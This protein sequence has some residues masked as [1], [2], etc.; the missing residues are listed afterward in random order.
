MDY[1]VNVENTPYYQWQLELLIESF[2]KN[3]IEDKLFI[4]IST[5]ERVKINKDFY[6]NISSHKRIIFVKNVGEEKGF[7]SLNLPYSLHVAIE[8][9][10]ISQ[11]FTV[12]EPDMVLNHEIKMEATDTADFLFDVDP[13]FTLENAEKNVGNFCEWFGKDREKIKKDWFPIGICYALNNFPKHFF[14]KVTK[15]AE[16]LALHQL[17]QGNKIWSNTVKLSLA[18]NLADNLSKINA[19]GT[20]DLVSQATSPSQFPFISY[21]QGM[22]P[23]FHKSMFSYPPP[24]YFSFGDPIETLSNIYYT[25]NIKFVSELASKSLENRKK[26]NG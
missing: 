17:L 21:K 9:D 22:L 23:Q 16:K 26:N 8:K 18:L 1:F 14:Y 25:P 6:T 5:D 11:P 24:S 20:Y 2:K 13:F 12:I 7:S 3:E 19:R 4:A 15:D 10:L